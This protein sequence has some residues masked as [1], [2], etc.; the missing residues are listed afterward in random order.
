[1]FPCIL[2]LYR[3]FFGKIPEDRR[4]KTVIEIEEIFGAGKV[5]E[6][7]ESFGTPMVAEVI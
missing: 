1:M 6:G 3:E 4:R 7:E 5:T 2:Y